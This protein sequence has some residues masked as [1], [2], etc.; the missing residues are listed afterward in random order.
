MPFQ[1]LF[2]LLQE[3]E[4]Q[5]CVQK[6]AT[7]LGLPIRISLSYVPKGFRPGDTD[8]F[9]TTALARTDW[10]GHGIESI[11]AQVA[12][13]QHLPMLGTSG[14]HGYPIWVRVSEDCHEQPATFV[15]IMAHELSHVPLASLCHPKKDSE[16]HTDLVPI[17]LGFRN[18]VQ[19]GR[20][21]V[22]S[23]TI[24]N[25]TTTRT[26]TYGYLTDSHFDFACNHARNILK[27][28]QRQ[29]KRV[30]E[31]VRQLHRKLHIATRDLARFRD[32][33]RY[34]DAHPVKKMRQNDGL[35]VVQ[36]HAWDY[37]RDWE[38]NITRVRSSLGEAEAFVRPLSHYTRSAVEQIEE[39]T[40][41][42]EWASE[43]LDQLIKGITRDVRTLQRYVPLLYRMRNSLWP[44]RGGGT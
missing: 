10:T 43:Q 44:R 25:E 34:L 17:L 37:T 14:L 38:I 19:G 7:G 31:L 33:L 24:G 35:R 42:L 5:G 36:F 29:K 1:D 3:K 9:R 13:P 18:V 21:V 39:H 22:E 15:A 6:I 30:T 16:L 2:S 26:T 4:T 41:N 40:R 23:T 11:T 32:Y 28:H 20:K 8:R 12:V 27:R